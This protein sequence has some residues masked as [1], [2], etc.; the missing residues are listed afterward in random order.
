MFKKLKGSKFEV[1]RDQIENK[2]YKL[3]TVNSINI[4]QRL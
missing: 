2:E 3:Y 1:F 4:I